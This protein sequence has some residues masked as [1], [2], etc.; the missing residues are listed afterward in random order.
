MARQG[1]DKKTAQHIF[2][3]HHGERA[4]EELTDH[5]PALSGQRDPADPESDRKH[6]LEPDRQKAGH[7]HHQ[8]NHHGAD[9]HES[10]T[11]KVAAVV[12][13]DRVDDVICGQRCL[14]QQID[15]LLELL[16]LQKVFDQP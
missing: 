7:Q 11:I 6:A 10:D 13:T 4:V 12:I 9:L 8:S 14:R 1:G 16:L 15:C 2:P 3:L 5:L